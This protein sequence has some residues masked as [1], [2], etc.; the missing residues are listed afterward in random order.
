MLSI[1]TIEQRFAHFHNQ[2]H[3]SF[4]YYKSKVEPVC[5]LILSDN[6]KNQKCNEMETTVAQQS[7]IC[8]SRDGKL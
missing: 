8:V 4:T 6:Y 1:L 7:Q 5:I 3:E 2:T